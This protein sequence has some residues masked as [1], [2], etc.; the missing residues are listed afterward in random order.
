MT[1][2]GRAAPEPPD[3]Q[4]NRNLENAVML[5]SLWYWRQREYGCLARW[6]ICERFR[7]APQARIPQ[8]W[9]PVLR[10]EYAQVKRVEHFLTANRIPLCRKML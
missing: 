7:T 10:I 4:G 1:E 3:D 5:V 2:G 9:V 8:K 6:L